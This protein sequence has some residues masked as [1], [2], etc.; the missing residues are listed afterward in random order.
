MIRAASWHPWLIRQIVNSQVLGREHCG[1]CHYGG[2]QRKASRA[3]RTNLASDS[4]S[5]PI[6]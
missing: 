1:C 2:Q 4:L 5:S 6:V 3:S